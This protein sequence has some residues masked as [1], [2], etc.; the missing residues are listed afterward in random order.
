MTGTTPTTSTLCRYF[1]ASGSCYYGDQC[2]FSHSFR[3]NEH[4]PTTSVITKSQRPCRNIALHGY[5]KFAG[6]GCEYNHDLPRDETRLL[7]AS[8]GN[9]PEGNFAKK[10]TD[11]IND[12]IPSLSLN[13]KSSKEDSQ[14]LPISSHLSQSQTISHSPPQSQLQQTSPSMQ[15][16]TSTLSHQFSDMMLNDDQQQ[17][18]PQP[19]QQPRT[20]R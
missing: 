9:S 8:P 10:A 14:Q 13:P 3:P 5:C 4:T 1:A 12:S 6:K 2:N 15:S 20:L 11:K 7:D 19:Q 16:Q 17:S 18:Q